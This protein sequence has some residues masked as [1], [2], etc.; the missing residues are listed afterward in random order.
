VKL[1]VV[2]RITQSVE[3]FGQLSRVYTLV[4]PD[5]PLKLRKQRSCIG[6]PRSNGV[7]TS[8]TASQTHSARRTRSI[9]S[10][11][12]ALSPADSSNPVIGCPH[13]KEF[14]MASNASYGS[15]CSGAGMIIKIIASLCLMFRMCILQT[16]FFRL[17][18]LSLAFAPSG[19]GFGPG[20]TLAQGRSVAK[21]SVL[22]RLLISMLEA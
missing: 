3:S 1:V 7:R 22:P 8:T 14:A 12:K 4:Q 2:R 21:S 13:R 16:L 6:G 15:L 18:M 19:T 10:W 17:E 9:R 5:R 20:N 11:R